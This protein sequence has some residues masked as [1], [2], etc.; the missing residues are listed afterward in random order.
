MGKRFDLLAVL[1][2]VGVT[3]NSWDFWL[4]RQHS[5]WGAFGVHTVRIP[6]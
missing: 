4:G 2:L 1:W 3:Q 6:L 5:L